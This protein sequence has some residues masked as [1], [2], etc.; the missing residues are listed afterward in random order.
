MMIKSVHSWRLLCSSCSHYH[1]H[2]LVLS[3]FQIL[4]PILYVNTLDRPQALVLREY[5]Y[6][7]KK[8]WH[9]CN[10]FVS[11]CNF[12]PLSSSQKG[13]LSYLDCGYA[14]V[15]VIIFIIRCYPFFSS[16]WCY[17]LCRQLYEQCVF[18]LI[19]SENIFPGDILDRDI[20]EPIPFAFH[21]EYVRL[22]EFCDLVELEIYDLDIAIADVLVMIFIID[23]AFFQ[24]KGSIW[25][26]LQYFFLSSAYPQFDIQH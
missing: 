19:H 8:H 6:P 22:M 10:P 24:Q 13:N 9:S 11:D 23:F 14:L 15:L 17:R 1:F 2:N 20:D 26:Y 4:K 12:D 18:H 3:F 21:C 25:C 5:V 16:I 7:I